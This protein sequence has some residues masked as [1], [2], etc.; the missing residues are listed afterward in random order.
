MLFVGGV[1]QKA[2]ACERAGID[3]FI[4]PNANVPDAKLYT[5]K[6][7]IVGVSSLREAIA[8]AK[9]RGLAWS[10]EPTP[11]DRPS[12]WRIVW[13]RSARPVKILWG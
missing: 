11:Y 1:A 7:K 3:V 9:S 10:C 6:L 5:H 2:L 8:A 12:F 4:V 13:N